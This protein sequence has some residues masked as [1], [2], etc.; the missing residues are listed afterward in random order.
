[1]AAVDS[2]AAVGG[3]IGYME[4]ELVTGDT[5]N[6]YMGGQIIHSYFTGKLNV[7][8]DIY[9][10]AMAGVVGENL[11]LTTE[12]GEQNYFHN[13]MY[14]D[15]SGARLAFGATLA[16]E[17]DYKTVADIGAQMATAAEIAGDEAYRIIM[18]IFNYQT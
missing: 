11:Y 17:H 2:F 1:M 9:A 12:S 13:N 3:L 18:Q 7:G 5:E 14:L 16:G 10:G 8:D 6:I 4:E 15:K